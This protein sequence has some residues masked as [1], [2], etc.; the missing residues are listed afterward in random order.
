MDRHLAAL[1][2]VHLVAEQLV[3]EFIN[4][5]AAVGQGTLLPV[6]RHD[7]V[8]IIQCCGTADHGSFFARALHV[9]AQAA[10]PLGSKHSLVKNSGSDHGPVYTEGL[11]FVEIRSF[12]A[13]VELAV[14]FQELEGGNPE[15]R[16]VGKHWGIHNFGLCCCHNPLPG[17][18]A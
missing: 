15:L 18:V 12:G 14:L 6:L 9:K 11:V 13:L 4:G 10:L 16:T 3:H 5:K 1:A 7:H 2:I 8:A 17:V